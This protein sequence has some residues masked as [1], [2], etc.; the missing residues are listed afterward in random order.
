MTATLFVNGHDNVLDM[1]S[2]DLE[3]LYDEVVPSLANRIGGDF[4]DSAEVDLWQETLHLSSLNDEDFDYAYHL[5]LQACDKHQS[6]KKYKSAIDE[7]FKVDP[8]F[9]T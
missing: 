3:L 2:T 6:L 9:N 8:R 7:L 5:A 4:A 1:K